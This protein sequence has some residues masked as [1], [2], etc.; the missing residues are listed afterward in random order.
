MSAQDHRSILFL[1]SN[2]SRSA[3][4]FFKTANRILCQGPVTGPIYTLAPALVVQDMGVKSYYIAHWGP[5]SVLLTNT[6]CMFTICLMQ[7]WEN[8]SAQDHR[9]IYFLFSNLSR[10][11]F[12]FFKTANMILCQGPVTGPVYRLARALV[13]R[14]MNLFCFCFPIFQDLLSNLSI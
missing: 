7:S 2:L 10:S 1:F 8:M 14:T 13:L 11:V 12:Q 4:Q 3:F 6:V 9:F 5:N